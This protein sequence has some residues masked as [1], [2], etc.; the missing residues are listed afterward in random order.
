[1]N[2]NPLKN[3]FLKNLPLSLQWHFNTP[4]KT[5]TPE[6]I[7]PGPSIGQVAAEIPG[8]V[9]KLIAGGGLQ[10]LFNNQP[11]PTLPQA[12]QTALT[13]KVD[14]MTMG[15][16]F[17]VGALENV[18]GQTAKAVAPGVAQKVFQDVGNLS[19]KL[20]GKLEGR[21]TVSKQFIEDLLKSPDLKKKEVDITKDVLDSMPEG[22]IDINDFAKKVQDELLPLKISNSN[23]YGPG[24]RYQYMVLPD[25]VRGP[26]ANYDERIYESPIKTSAGSIHFD[27]QAKNY[28]GHTRIEDMAAREPEW[29]GEP[30]RNLGV[31]DTR[32]VIE[33]QSDL[34]QKGNL[35]KE[36]KPQTLRPI[37]GTDRELAEID[38]FGNTEVRQAGETAKRNEERSKEVQ[39]LQQYSD[40]TAHFR[41]AR[42]EIAQAAKDG[43]TKLQF[44][45]GE[46]A[47]NIERLGEDTSWSIFSGGE[48]WDDLRV[49]NIE[50]GQEIYNKND[51]RTDWII[52][53]VL[54]D[55]KFKAVPKNNLTK[56]NPVPGYDTWGEVNGEFYPKV[57]AENFD[58]S[59]K[60]DT[61]NPIYKFYESTLG[62]YLKNRHGAKLVTDPQGVTW[63]EVPITK[64]QGIK[65]V[66]AFGVAAPIGLTTKKEKK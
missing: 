25:D 8:Q 58:I 29:P 36:A 33:V 19:T 42:E 59:G 60:V 37:S 11:A 7:Q 51:I 61:S 47:M 1:M 35:E 10:S 31:G 64:E 53:D 17:S 6:T 27:S 49:D 50:V 52:T 44:P 22:K 28:F 39:K 14:P 12:V 46:T 66:E 21:A 30:I 20:L 62:K 55:G 9:N 2:E 4:S 24:G 57:A 13:R 48:Y 41:M 56:R 32:R 43:K 65:P 63:W 16:S 45:T 34:Y 23:D 18:A 3:S 26:V 15:T 54:G 38:R 40:P 5:S